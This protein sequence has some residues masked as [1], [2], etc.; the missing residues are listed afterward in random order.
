M[1]WPRWFLNQALRFGFAFMRRWHQRR[2]VRVFNRDPENGRH[3]MKR[4]SHWH[5]KIKDLETV[6]P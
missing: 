4:A 3:H 5:R 6:T 1:S 2:V